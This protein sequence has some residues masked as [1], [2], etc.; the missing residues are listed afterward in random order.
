MAAFKLLVAGIAARDRPTRGAALLNALAPRC[1]RRLTSRDLGCIRTSTTFASW[2]PAIRAPVTY[3][4]N[5]KIMQHTTACAAI[6]SSVTTSFF[7]FSRAGA[8]TVAKLQS[9]PLL[10]ADGAS[11]KITLLSDASPRSNAEVA[12]I[13]GS[14]TAHRSN[15]V[16]LLDDISLRCTRIRPAKQQVL[17]WFREAGVDRVVA[18]TPGA[19]SST[20]TA[21][22][23]L[24][25][26]DAGCP[27]TRI[28]ASVGPHRLLWL[29]LDQKGG[30]GA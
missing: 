26:C 5:T 1:E 6:T 3:R 21:T 24:R 30:S 22:E 15:L 18:T 2:R 8:S 11:R 29:K 9:T 28:H 7:F 14:I 20:Y 16:V 25:A 17:S 19:A 23:D 27:R 10:Q 4:S 12:E 13:S